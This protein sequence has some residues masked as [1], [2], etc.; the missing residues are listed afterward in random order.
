MEGL[1]NGQNKALSE[2][3]GNVAV[4]WFAAGVVAPILVKQENFTGF[5]LKGLISLSLATVFAFGSVY[6]ARKIKQ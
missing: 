5:A 4:A 3:S 1:S 2:I 6:L